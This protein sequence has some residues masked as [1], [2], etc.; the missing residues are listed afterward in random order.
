M[1]AYQ[2]NL[3]RHL[4]SIAGIAAAFGTYVVFV[5]YPS[6]ESSYATANKR[7]RQAARQRQ[8]PLVDVVP[9]FRQFCPAEPCPEFLYNDHHPTKRG[10]EIVAEAL[11]HRL[12]YFGPLARA[13][14]ER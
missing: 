11:M 2:V 10:H 3:V 5:T 13:S 8:T 4:E 12:L 1:G 14:G 7:I 9:R 6:E